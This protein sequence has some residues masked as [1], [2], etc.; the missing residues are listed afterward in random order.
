MLYAAEGYKKS[1]YDI[2]FTNTDHVLVR[3]FAEWME[4]Y[5]EIR[6]SELKIQVRIYENMDVTAEE[7]FWLQALGMQ[8]CQ[9]HKTQVMKLRPGS[10]TYKDTA[11]HGTCRLYK[12]SVTKKMELMLSIEAFFDTYTGHLRA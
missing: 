12:A 10:F 9:L 6:Q 7:T 5:L 4:Q 8:R 1:R 2:S 3:F 11:R